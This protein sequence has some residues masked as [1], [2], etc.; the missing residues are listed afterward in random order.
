MTEIPSMTP[1]TR[2]SASSE[3]L[4][5]KDRRAQRIVKLVNLSAKVVGLSATAFIMFGLYWWG[6]PD[7]LG[8]TTNVDDVFLI[9]AAI[10]AITATLPHFAIEPIAKAARKL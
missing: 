5:E 2:I 8:F 3:E 4:N 10:L 1:Q 6:V 7:G 9:R